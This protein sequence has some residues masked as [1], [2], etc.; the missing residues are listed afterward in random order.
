MSNLKRHIFLIGF[1]GTGKS[2]VSKE[3]AKLMNLKVL[4][5]DALIVEAGGESITEIF[6]QKG[7]VYF[8]QLETQVLEEISGFEKSIISCGGGLPLKIENQELMKKAGKVILLTA[9]A[10]NIYKR[11]KE[12][13]QRPLLKDNMNEEYIEGLMGKRQAAYETAADIIVETDNKN[14]VEICEEIVLKLK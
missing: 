8:R 10:E 13:N 4:D 3:L 12:D 5:T 6:E 9:S 2:A 1:M 7:E 11:V 14:I